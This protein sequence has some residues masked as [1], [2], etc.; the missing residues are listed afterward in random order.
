MVLDII[1]TLLHFPADHAIWDKSMKTRGW[2]GTTVNEE[3]V[4]QDCHFCSL[5]N[6]WS[7]QEDFAYWPV[8]LLGKNFSSKLGNN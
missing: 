4:V 7:S 5:F 2:V 8:K 3:L 1:A 6:N